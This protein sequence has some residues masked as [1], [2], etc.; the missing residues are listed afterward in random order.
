MTALSGALILYSVLRA[1]RLTAEEL[2]APA[3]WG[4]LAVVFIAFVPLHE[5]LHLIWH[6]SVPF[7][8]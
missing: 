5:L 7:R 2:A 4:I 8:N 6:P 3:P 1:N